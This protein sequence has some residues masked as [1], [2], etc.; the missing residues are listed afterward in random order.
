MFCPRCDSVY[1]KATVCSKCGVKLLRAKGKPKRTS[2]SNSHSL[3]VMTI[4]VVN[5]FFCY[6]DG[7]N[8]TAVQIVETGGNNKNMI[9]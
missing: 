1:R 7:I 9:G 8:T 5:M 6:K 4:V 2:L 3:L